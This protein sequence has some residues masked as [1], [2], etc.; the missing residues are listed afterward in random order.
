MANGSHR[1]TLAQNVIKN[2]SQSALN[3]AFK[4]ENETAKSVKKIPL[5][6]PTQ[7]NHSK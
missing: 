6:Y 3:D 5:K 7:N 4:N 2:A 1:L